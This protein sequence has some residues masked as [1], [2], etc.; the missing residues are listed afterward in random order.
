MTVD[1]RQ[2]LAWADLDQR[3][4]RSGRIAGTAIVA[5]VVGLALGAEAAH[6]GGWFDSGRDAPGVGY[7]IAVALGALVPTMLA[8]PQR[9]FWRADASMVARMPIAGAALWYV[10]VVRAARGAALGVVVAAPTVVI[11]V[12]A[13]RELGARL[14]AVVG[15]LAVTATAT[16]PAVCLAAAH[17]VAS[18]Q[19]SAATRALAGE[20]EVATTTWLGALPGFTIAGVVI[21][22]VAAARWIAV[23][24]PS[25]AIVIVVVVAAAIVAAVAA[26][27][28]APRI[29]PRAMREVA[30][31]DR[32]ILA[33]LDIHP[34]TGLERAVAAR[35]DPGA[36]QVLDR[37]VR[38]TRRRYPL[39]A[40]G[41]AAGG[42]TLLIV[43]LARPD[44]TT[45]LVI[46]ALAL[47]ALGVTVYRA[48]GRDPLEL[49]RSTATL[50]IAPAAV[51]R[52]RRTLLA[53]W[54]AVWMLVPLAVAI[55]RG[56]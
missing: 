26:T 45:W 52:A 2:L 6:R 10:A 55:A 46:L 27:V 16:I 19:A 33:H 53:V 41:G 13:D 28:A 36:A 22:V 11:A 15:A 21:A 3:R 29:Y 48:S 9:M 43:A 37:L 14:A 50:P 34:A 47:A 23:A 31:L 24:E 38:L 17:V 20:Y 39:F 35:L 8:T 25:G 40:L 44:A 56:A 1:G 30:A 32:Q 7:L 51:A 54:L 12:I 5:I 42:V 4:R 49:P 18:G